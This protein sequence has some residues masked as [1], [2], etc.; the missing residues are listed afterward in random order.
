VKGRELFFYIL[1][2]PIIVTALSQKCDADTSF[3][4]YIWFI[5]KLV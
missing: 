2:I 1:L 3:D 5:K 4:I